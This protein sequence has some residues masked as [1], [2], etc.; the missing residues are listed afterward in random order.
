MCAV[1]LVCSVRGARLAHRP[2]GWAAHFEEVNAGA[3]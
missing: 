3:P 1:R 2:L